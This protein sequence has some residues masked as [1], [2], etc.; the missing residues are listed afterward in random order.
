MTV[1]EAH[2]L[3]KH[4]RKRRVV[5]GVSLEV[6][7][8]KVIGLLGPNGAGKTTCFYMIVGLVPVEEGSIFLNH[9]DVTLLPMHA[10]ARLGLGYLA[11]EPSTFRKLS[12]RNNILAIVP[13]PEPM[14]AI[15]CSGCIPHSCR[16]SSSN[17][18]G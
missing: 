6:A 15:A 1:L 12:T 13:V 5:N 9:N 4:Y 17:S 2:G 16:N 10:R 18:T 14:S 7:S 3:I 8:G 11:Q